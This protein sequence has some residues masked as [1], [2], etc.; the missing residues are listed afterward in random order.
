MDTRLLRELACKNT[1]PQCPHMSPQEFLE[2]VAS[3]AS[4]FRWMPF[5]GTPRLSPF[6][7]AVLAQDFWLCHPYFVGSRCE[8]CMDL[9]CPLPLPEDTQ[10]LSAHRD[11]WYYSSNRRYYGCWYYIFVGVCIIF[12]IAAIYGYFVSTTFG[13]GMTAGFLALLLFRI[14]PFRDEEVG[15]RFMKRLADANTVA[16]RLSVLAEIAAAYVSN[17]IWIDWFKGSAHPPGLPSNIARPPD[18]GAGPLFVPG[19]PNEDWLRVRSIGPGQLIETRVP[20]P[21]DS[22]LRY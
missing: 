11:S 5:N 17:R 16:E 21:E 9:R 4:K 2:A 3:S 6:Q 12:F 8:Q 10:R 13:V 20:P 7:I 18:V 15:G 19:Y 1:L 14:L 22:V